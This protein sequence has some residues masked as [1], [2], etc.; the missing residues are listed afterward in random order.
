MNVYIFLSPINNFKILLTSSHN[1][2]FFNFSITQVIHIQSIH[3]SNTTLTTNFF[4]LLREK[5]SMLRTTE[6][7][8]FIRMKARVFVQ[9]EQPYLLFIA[10]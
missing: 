6:I 2:V 5:K 9:C 1:I 8:I 10:K 4:T 3:Q 7:T